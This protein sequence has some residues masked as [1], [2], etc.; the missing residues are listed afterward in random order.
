[1]THS[2]LL[3]GVGGQG[4]LLA[5]K[6]I[7]EAAVASGY[8][9]YSNEI[10]GMAQRGGCVTA[11][12]RFGPQVHSP[13]ILEG[14]ADV[15]ASA[16]GVLLDAGLRCTLDRRPRRVPVDAAIAT[17]RESIGAAVRASGLAFDA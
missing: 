3:S 7:G 6:I 4:I 9:V 11:Q 10:H 16:H 14:T 17:A 8:E 2:I 13:L 5:A 1:M 15:L 12:V